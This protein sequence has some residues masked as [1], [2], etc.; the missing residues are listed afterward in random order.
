MILAV[1]I[2]NTNIVLGCIDEEKV[3]FEC[4]ISTDKHKTE[5]EYTVVLNNILDVYKIDLSAIRGVIL[6][7]VVPPITNAV[8]KALAFVTGLNVME[9]TVHLKHDLKINSDN[10][11]ELGIDM[12][13]SAVAAL[14]EHKPPFILFDMGTATTISVIDE[15]GA[16]QGC[17]IL[18]G[19]KISLEALTARASQLSSISL[20]APE[21][22]VS[23]NTE[24]C[25]QSGIVF[26][27]AA[28]MDGMIDR[29]EKEIGR[30]ATVIAT[31]GLARAIVPYCSHKI[32]F[33]DEIMLRGL[34][35]LYC[36][37]C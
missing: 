14:K 1:D 18:P 27:N 6:S 29:I 32:L 28:M 33:D 26:G 19:V 2:G 20:K 30:S 36:D 5:A 9:A 8:K 3:Y 24:E 22:V 7:S 13:V 37:N 21:Y 31:G 34:W 12:V 10:P 17:S 23:K 35:Y 11:E 16:F 25:M 15:N 4:R